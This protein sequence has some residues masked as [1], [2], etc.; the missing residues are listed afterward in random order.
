MTEKE[1]QEEIVRLTNI[2]DRHNLLDLQHA[3]R[4]VELE[5]KYND[6]V[7][8]L[9]YGKSL[10]Q[11]WYDGLDIIDKLKMVCIGS[12]TCKECPIYKYK[13]DNNMNICCDDL[14]LELL[15]ELFDNKW[16]RKESE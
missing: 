15:H 5:T 10:I 1:M 2:V 4:M 9:I 8:D 7:D 16:E 12:I 6:L 13:R 3:K 14:S 11:K